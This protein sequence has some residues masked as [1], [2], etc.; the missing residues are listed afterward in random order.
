MIVYKR[1]T[2]SDA[3]LYTDKNANQMYEWF[4]SANIY[5]CFPVARE[6]KF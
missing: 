4:P 1:K 2:E 6:L 5:L 3:N